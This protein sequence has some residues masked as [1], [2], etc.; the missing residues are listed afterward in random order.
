MGSEP[1]RS[2]ILSAS[3]GFLLFDEKMA[4]II[5]KPLFQGIFGIKK[6]AAGDK[7]VSL[8]A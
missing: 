2:M 1:V 6:Y 4:E 8:T 3:D 7:I 5:P